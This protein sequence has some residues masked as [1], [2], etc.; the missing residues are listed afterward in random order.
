[1]TF[2]TLFDYFEHP[3]I[4]HKIQV[5]T[6]TQY[7]SLLFRTNSVTSHL[8]FHWVNRNEPLDCVILIRV[9]NNILKNKCLLLP[10]PTAHY[11]FFDKI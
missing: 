11:L 4:D 6:F 3:K 5:T 2:Y 9:Y 1:M 10:L 8:N 7:P